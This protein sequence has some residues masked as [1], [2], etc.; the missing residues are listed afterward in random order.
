MK[1]CLNHL[2]KSNKGSVFINAKKAIETSFNRGHRRLN[3]K[4][5][6]Y[7]YWASSSKLQ[8][9]SELSSKMSNSLSH[10]L[11]FKVKAF[12]KRTTNSN[13]KSVK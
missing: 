1:H 8:E 5:Q 7:C 6:Y 13:P 10:L 12:F 11:G 3:V 2:P 4:D 9:Y